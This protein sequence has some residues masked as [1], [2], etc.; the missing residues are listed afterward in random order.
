[1]PGQWVSRATLNSVFKI[2]ALSCITTAVPKC[3][4]KFARKFV[5]KCARNLARNFAPNFAPN[6]P[7]NFSTHLPEKFRAES[8]SFRDQMGQKSFRGSFGRSL[9]RSLGQSF[10]NQFWMHCC[11]CKCFGAAMFAMTLWI[12][13]R[14]GILGVGCWSCLPTEF[15]M[16]C[17]RPA[18][19][20]NF[21]S[22]MLGNIRSHFPLWQHYP[23]VCKRKRQR[24]QP[25]KL[26]HAIY[27]IFRTLKVH[28]Q[29]IRTGNSHYDQ[30][31]TACQDLNH[32]RR[33][34]P[35]T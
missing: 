14:H 27:E 16:R 11:T 4:Q 3:A 29:I 5:R 7:E 6:F 20:S 25:S 2:W 24:F 18:A 33:L 23:R 1:M 26:D 21:I 34:A 15:A 13:L 8:Y 17:R 10:W 19:D 31:T 12:V 32:Q 9:G 28:H 30:F 22:L 35:G